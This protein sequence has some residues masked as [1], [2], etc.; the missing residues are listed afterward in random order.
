[1]IDARTHETRAR[2]PVGG[3]PA[4]LA[5]DPDSECAYVGCESTDEVAVIDLRRQTVLDLIKAGTVMT[6]DSPH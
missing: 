5:F 4:H 1:V 3:A 2:L 6:G